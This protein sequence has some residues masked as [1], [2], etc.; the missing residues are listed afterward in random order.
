MNLSFEEFVSQVTLW[1]PGASEVGSFRNCTAEGRIEEGRILYEWQ[2][3]QGGFGCCSYDSRDSPPWMA[4]NGRGMSGRGDT[5]EEADLDER[6]RYV[7]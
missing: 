1:W 2:V 7:P 6:A 3:D 5:L 4:D